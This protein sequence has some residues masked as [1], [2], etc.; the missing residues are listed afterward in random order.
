MA[1]C[2]VPEALAQDLLVICMLL[3]VSLQPVT[4]PRHWVQC[5]LAVCK[6]HDG[7]C[8]GSMSEGLPAQRQT[9]TRHRGESNSVEVE[10]NKVWRICETEADTSGLTQAAPHFSERRAR[11]MCLAR[12]CTLYAVRLSSALCRADQLQ[13]C[14]T[15]GRQ[16]LWMRCTSSSFACRHRHVATLM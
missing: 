13:L 16:K 6:R 2:A 7:N 5:Y 8:N 15:P 10:R 4:R 9:R 11:K 14:L 3:T 12:A 1:H